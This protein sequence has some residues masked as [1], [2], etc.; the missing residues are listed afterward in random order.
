M[1]K[2]LTALLLERDWI[3]ENCCISSTMHQCL[4]QQQGDDIKVV[5]VDTTA[6]V[7]AANAPAWELMG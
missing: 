7:A 3:H 2:G 5:S 4:I 1:E 6:S